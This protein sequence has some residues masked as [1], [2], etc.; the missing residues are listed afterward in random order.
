MYVPFSRPLAENG[1]IGDIDVQ[2]HNAGGVLFGVSD[3]VPALEDYISA[4][5]TSA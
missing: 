2:F 1:V 5:I 3:Y 4:A